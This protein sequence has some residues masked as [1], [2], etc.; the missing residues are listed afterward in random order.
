MDLPFDLSS[1][2]ARVQR[3]ASFRYRLFYG[4]PPDAALSQF[5]PCDFELDGVRYRWAEQWMMASKARLFGDA[6]ALDL[7]MRAARPRECQAV[8][9]TVQGFD[10]AEWV[11][12]AFEIVVAGNVA[13]FGQSDALREYLL[14]TGDDILVE[15]S[16]SDKLWGIGRSVLDPLAH[17]PLQWRGLNQ[18]GFAL[19]KARALL[20]ARKS[21]AFAWLPDRVLLRKEL[22]PP[23]WRAL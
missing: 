17:D 10:L 14:G 20:R 22:Q 16:P 15:A 19:T 21:V 13:K 9:R 11:H 7:I 23:S 5:H 8:G 1:L 3:G 2:R 18:L 12:Y 4:D 6:E